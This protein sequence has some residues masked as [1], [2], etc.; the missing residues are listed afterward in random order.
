M[1]PTMEV[2]KRRA[3][4]KR[5]FWWRSRKKRR[6]LPVEFFVFEVDKSKKVTLG[7]DL[8]MWKSRKRGKSRLGSLRLPHFA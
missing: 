4:L 8:L 7:R 6:V 3:L 5:V 1:G 2:E